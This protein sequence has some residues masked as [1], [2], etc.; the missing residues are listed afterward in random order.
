MSDPR[1]STARSAGAVGVKAVVP[2]LVASL[3]PSGRILDFGAGPKA[4]H[5]L[6][7][8][9]L[10]L[11]VVAH[12]LP[13]NQTAVHDAKALSRKYSVVMAS[14]VLNVQRNRQ[15]VG[16]TIRELRTVVAVRGKVYCNF[17]SS[18]NH[19][20]L[21]PS[22]IEDM[23]RKAFSHVGRVGHPQVGKNRVWECRK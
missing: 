1:C 4:I 17:P 3:Q 13:E 15:Q 7:L 18:P 19:T 21:T 14:N 8:R 20:G 5:T 22:Q 12:E 6:K 10:G 11:N 2:R 9:S 23:L 16:R